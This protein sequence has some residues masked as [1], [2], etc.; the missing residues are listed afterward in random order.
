M[1]LPY[2]VILLS[3]A[4]PVDPTNTNLDVEVS[5]EDDRRYGAT[6]ATPDNI[7]SLMRPYES[8]G[9]CGAGLYFWSSAL[10]VI[11][12]CSRH[13]IEECVASLLA[14]GEFEDAF[15]RL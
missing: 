15:S 8:S 2:Q 14:E 4:E 11:K 12:D 6:F 10:I 13:S 9:E 7:A 3:S 5:F 1:S